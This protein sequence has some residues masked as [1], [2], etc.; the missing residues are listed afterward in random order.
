MKT[1][2]TSI[3]ISL[4]CTTSF[5][6]NDHKFP[7]WTFHDDSTT[8]SG[9]AVGLNTSWK[10]DNV[11]VNGLNLELLGYG[12]LLPLIPMDPIRD[13][14]CYNDD[15]IH[16]PKKIIVNGINI[17]PS[18]MI[19]EGKVNGLNLNGMGS[20]LIETNGASLTIFGNFTE[21]SNGLQAAFYVNDAA[22]MNGLQFSFIGNVVHLYS[23]GIQAS[24]I[25]YSENHKGLQIGLA[26]KSVKLKGIQIGL[27]NVNQKRKFPIV[28][29]N[30]T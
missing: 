27:W 22:Y 2:I 7:V 17:S 14:S 1:L 4:I 11:R 30:F 23:K 26:N 29:W 20:Y 19:C 3:I 24:A 13:D 10:T 25:N 5:S 15:R 12:F 18:G 8:I 6:Q 16:L 9:M 21:K 28:N